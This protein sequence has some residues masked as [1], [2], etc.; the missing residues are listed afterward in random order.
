MAYA[1]LNAYS[2]AS[3][4]CG[5]DGLCFKMIGFPRASVGNA[6][7]KHNQKGKFHGKMT[8]I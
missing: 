7:L 4:H 5:V 6:D 2:K 3:A 1:S 8:V